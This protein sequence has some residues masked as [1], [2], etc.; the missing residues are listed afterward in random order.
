ML[1]AF[2]T[3]AARYQSTPNVEVAVI[4]YGSYDCCNANPQGVHQV[5]GFASPGQVSVREID[6][7]L[8]FNYSFEFLDSGIAKALE[9]I[10]HQCPQNVDLTANPQCQHKVIVLLS[11]G[12]PGVSYIQYYY[13]ADDELPEKLLDDVKN[14]GIAVNTICLETD[15]AA[16]PN[17]CNDYGYIY[18][19][20][21][22]YF[23]LT[24][25]N[26]IRLEKM[27][28]LTGGK[29]FGVVR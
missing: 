27:S 25:L 11:D 16:P 5:H 14:A 19:R 18:V 28:T 26:K 2:D 21:G 20:G 23:D 4:K 10:N 12:A 8:S 13:T 6:D 15:G 29:Y 9:M 3:L 22:K 7:N 1:S 17:S 24:T